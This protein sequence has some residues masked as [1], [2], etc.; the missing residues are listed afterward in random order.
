MKPELHSSQKLD[1]DT[2]EKENYNIDVKIL[3]K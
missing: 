3:I 2:S 1:K